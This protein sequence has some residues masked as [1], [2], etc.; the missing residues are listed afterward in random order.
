MKFR[1]EHVETLGFFPQVKLNL[2]SSWR[3]IRDTTGKYELVYLTADPCATEE[4][5]IAI[6]RGYKEQEEQKKQ[7]LKVAYRKIPKTL[8]D[9]YHE[10]KQIE[11]ELF[12]TT[13]NTLQAIRQ[14]NADFMNT[15]S[16]FRKTSSIPTSL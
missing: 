14:S 11:K 15:L 12:Q 3:T 8:T 1:I 16:S 9:D 13:L 4:E 6:C 7:K 10:L 2:L 5:A